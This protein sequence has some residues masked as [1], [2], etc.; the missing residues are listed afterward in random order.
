MAIFGFGKPDPRPTSEQVAHQ[1]CALII[2]IPFII[3]VALGVF[4]VATGGPFDE[5]T[6]PSTG[7]QP[8]RRP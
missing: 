4:C 7:S 6:P 8:A 1:G 2:L 5:P 3:L